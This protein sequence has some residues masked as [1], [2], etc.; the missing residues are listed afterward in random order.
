MDKE[1]KLKI[2]EKHR[3]N[4]KDV[5]SCQVQVA[6]LTQ[7]IKDLSE[8]LKLHKKDHHTRY[9]LLNMVSRRRRLIN[10]LKRSD[11]DNYRALAESLELK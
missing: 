8:H 1:S 5:G 3:I 10:Y 4:D 7:K 6:V 9:G 11:G 2:I